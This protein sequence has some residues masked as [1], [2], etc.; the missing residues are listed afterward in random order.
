[1]Q[2][3]KEKKHLVLLEDDR[4]HL[5]LIRSWDEM[6]FS[7]R[8]G[9]F[10]LFLQ[11]LPTDPFNT[12]NGVQGFR[13]KGIEKAQ[14]KNILLVQTPAHQHIIYVMLASCNWLTLTLLAT[15]HVKS[16]H[17]YVGEIDRCFHWLLIRR[18]AHQHLRTP[19]WETLFKDIC[20]HMM[21]YFKLFVSSKCYK[22]W[23]QRITRSK[24]SYTNSF[25]ILNWTFL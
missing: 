14:N 18:K 15:T 9:F 12:Y 16:A 2:L 22:K 24:K 21:M 17:K 23:I 4:K 6:F 1:L 5:S 8:Q 13:V 3:E 7:P 25:V 11:C 20:E 19:G 10:T